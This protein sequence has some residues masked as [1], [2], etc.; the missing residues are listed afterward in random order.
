MLVKTY[1]RRLRWAHNSFFITV[2]VQTVHH[3]MVVVRMNLTFHTHLGMAVLTH[4]DVGLTKKG[5]WEIDR[6]RET[7][8]RMRA[9]P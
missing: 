7:L 1:E 2:P 3:P 4:A 8:D 9:W 5:A 6:F